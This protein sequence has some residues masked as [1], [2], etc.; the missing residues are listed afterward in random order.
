MRLTCI[1]F[2]PAATL[3]ST[4][5]VQSL[6]RQPL[7]QQLV[8]TKMIDIGAVYDTISSF[9]PPQALHQA[10]GSMELSLGEETSVT[11][12]STLTTPLF[13]A[14]L[15]REIFELAAQR[16]PCSIP[17]LMLVAWRVNAWVEPLLYR[18]IALRKDPNNSRGKVGGIPIHR[19]EAIMD[20]IQTRPAFLAR[21]VRNLLL[22]YFPGFDDGPIIS[23]CPHVENVW[24]GSDNLHA[25]LPIL[26]RLPLKHLYC[27]ISKLFGSQR[28]IQF[29]HPIF[30]QI[31][32]LELFDTFHSHIEDFL[33]EVW[34]NLALIPNLTHLAFDNVIFLPI[35]LTVLQA[36]SSLRVLLTLLEGTLRDQ[37]ELISALAKDPRFVKTDCSFYMKDWQMGRHVGVDYWSRAEEFVAKRKSG[38][39][40]QTKAS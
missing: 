16:R 21:S 6:K 25:L 27:S 29:T 39:I 8:P 12:Y 11:S 3:S 40:P 30:A 15:E 28:N 5:Q 4:K 18:T 32:H 37:K 22:A 33:P 10:S 24:T 23:A 2:S 38:K 7:S 14:E 20:L 36:C 17:A 26:E 9:C 34:C 1:A 19:R 31:T 13:P 35:C